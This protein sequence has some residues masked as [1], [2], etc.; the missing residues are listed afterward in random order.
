MTRT[1]L[2]NELLGLPVAALYEAAGQTGALPADLKPVG[3][4]RQ[5]A[6]PAFPVRCT[7]G[8][9][10]AIHRAV[11]AARP[12]DILVIG[13][14]RPHQRAL[15]GDMLVLAARLQK[16]GGIVLDGYVRD[17]ADLDEM[18]VPVF[19]KG[20]AVEGPLKSGTRLAKTDGSVRI[21]K[22]TVRRGD[23]IRGDADG[24]VVLPPDDLPALLEKAKARLKKEAELRVRMEKSGERLGALLGI[25]L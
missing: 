8:S 22:V 24:V 10:L 11:Y 25:P 13:Q 4:A 15:M 23:F 5:L 9:N 14:D 6:G 18:G 3:K 7:G 20:G 21:G 16:L 19:C 12:G 17:L 1:S 2:A